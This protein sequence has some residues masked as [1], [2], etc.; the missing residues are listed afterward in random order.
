MI[1]LSFGRWD[2]ASGSIFIRERLYHNG[3]WTPLCRIRFRYLKTI[4]E[5]HNEGKFDSF[6]SEEQL[7]QQFIYESAEFEEK[8][9]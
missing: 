4:R 5:R 2:S 7:S 1:V 3:K 9:V 8:N 6:L